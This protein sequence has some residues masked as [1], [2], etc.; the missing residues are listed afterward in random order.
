ML[1]KGMESFTSVVTFMVLGFGFG[2]G[3]GFWVWVTTDLASGL[4]LERGP[5]MDCPQI[6]C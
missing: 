2:F 1:V 3:F 4:V 5:T 6:S